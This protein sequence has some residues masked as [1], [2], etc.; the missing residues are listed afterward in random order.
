M[1]TRIEDVMASE[2]VGGNIEYAAKVLPHLDPAFF[3][4]AERG[5]F[6]AIREFV[7]KYHTCPSK[8]TVKVEIRGKDA[9]QSIEWL[10]HRLLNSFMRP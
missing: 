3:E 8:E 5:V 2:I 10:R 7:S 6:M 4:R 9:A 1:I